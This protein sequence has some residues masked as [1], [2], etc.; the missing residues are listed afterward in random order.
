MDGWME[1]DM[2]KKW[3][4]KTKQK[5]R[6]RTGDKVTRGMRKSRRRR[7]SSG[8]IR[9]ERKSL[10]STHLEDIREESRANPLTGEVI[11]ACK[12][13]EG[14]DEG[15]VGWWPHPAHLGKTGTDWYQQV[16]M[17][18]SRGHAA[19]PLPQLKIDNVAFKW[20]IDEKIRH[21]DR[22][23]QSW[24]AERRAH[25]SLQVTPQTTTTWVL[26]CIC[27]KTEYLN[28]IN[29]QSWCLFRL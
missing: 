2:N 4:L 21:T 19:G 28:S 22:F 7:G 1:W 14:T 6:K 13:G 16:K 23:A 8:K 10:I 11:K 27:P 25:W 3:D 5:G 26:V 17:F 18:L 12:T 24:Q 29:Q 20:V 15:S 9:G